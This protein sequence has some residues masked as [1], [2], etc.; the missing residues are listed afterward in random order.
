MTSSFILLLL[1]MPARLNTTRKAEKSCRHD[2]KTWRRG[3]RISSQ[4]LFP[5]AMESSIFPLLRNDLHYTHRRRID[6]H[7]ALL[8][9]GAFDPLR[10]RPRLHPISGQKVNPPPRSPP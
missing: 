4:W 10:P 5:P 3:E 2:L 6:P 1:L 8:R 7:T 9:H